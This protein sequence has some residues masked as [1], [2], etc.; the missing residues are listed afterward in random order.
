MHVKAV[1]AMLSSGELSCNVKFMIEG[2]EEVGS[3]NLGIF[4]KENK[5]K[6]THPMFFHSSSVIKKNFLAKL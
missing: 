5:E 1:E 4:I 6:L 2:E 3:E